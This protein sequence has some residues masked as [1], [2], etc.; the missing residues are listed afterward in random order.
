M[1]QVEWRLEVLNTLAQKKKEGLQVL[2]ASHNTLHVRAHI[3][4]SVHIC[5][6]MLLHSSDMHLYTV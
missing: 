5:N 2:I 6:G 1:A 4:T 3:Q